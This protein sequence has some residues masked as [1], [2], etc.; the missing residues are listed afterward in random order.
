MQ[1]LV[2]HSWN[3][4]HFQHNITKKAIHLLQ[5]TTLKAFYTGYGKVAKSC[6]CE[7]IL[8]TLML[9]FITLMTKYLFW[10]TRCQA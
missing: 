6:D 3:N 8:H 9:T 10:K 4:A 7:H 5:E 2:T 1:Q